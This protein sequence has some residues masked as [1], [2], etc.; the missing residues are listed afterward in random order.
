MRRKFEEIVEIDFTRAGDFGF[1]ARV[2][3]DFF[4]EVDAVEGFVDDGLE[5]DGLAAPVAHVSGD[6]NFGLRVGDAIAKRC[7]SES[8]VTTE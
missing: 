6:N 2:D 1:C 3:D 7:V 5:S 4:D 8:G